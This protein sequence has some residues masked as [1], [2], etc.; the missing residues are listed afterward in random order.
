MKI[1]EFKSRKK[2]FKEWIKS[3]IKENINDKQT[4]HCFIMWENDEYINNA[5][6]NCDLDT[7]KSFRN[8]LDDK[9]K[10]IE[11]CKLLDKYLIEE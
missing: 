4:N 1:I 3:V 7:L 10:E 5:Q 6:F 2:Q 9:I 11:F 8:V